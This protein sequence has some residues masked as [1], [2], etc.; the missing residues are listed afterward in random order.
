MLE[1]K[2]FLLYFFILNEIFILTYIYR[3]CPISNETHSIKCVYFKIILQTLN[4]SQNNLLLHQY[5]IPNNSAIH[6]CPHKSSTGTQYWKLNTHYSASSPYC[7]N[8]LTQIEGIDIL[9]RGGRSRMFDGWGCVVTLSFAMNWINLNIVL[10]IN[11]QLLKFFRD[12]LKHGQFCKSQR[13]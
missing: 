8:T 5:I 13:L 6:L 3:V 12:D 9:R 11:F 4:I 7:Q 10:I 1:K 2:C